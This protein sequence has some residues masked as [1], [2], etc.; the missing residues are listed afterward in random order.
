MIKWI[1]KKWTDP[2]WSSIFAGITLTALSGFI[3]LILSFVEQVSFVELFDK[4]KTSYIQVSYLTIIISLIVLLSLTVSIISISI[5]R[6]QLKHLKFPT[7]FKREFDLQN[8]LKGEWLETY[9]HY[10]EATM[11]GQ[12]R[13]TFV[14]GN[15]YYIG[16]SW[17]FVLTDIDLNVS[18]RDLK[19]TKTRCETN[20]KHARET[21]KIIDENTM[22][23]IDDLG[24]TINYRRM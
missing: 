24:C 14:N 2:F 13:V 23:G 20:Q 4:V 9:S 7:E 18:L 8:F 22:I 11:N 15:Q 3:S 5:M 21:L 16:N 12:E 19:W 10:S 17:V 6:F 1:K